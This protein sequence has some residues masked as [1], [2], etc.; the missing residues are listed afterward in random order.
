MLSVL[1]SRVKTSAKFVRILEQVK[2]LDCVSLWFLLICSRILPN[3]R[4][5]FHQAMKARKICF[6]S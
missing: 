1:K 2:T 6:I 3:L 5:G 4:L